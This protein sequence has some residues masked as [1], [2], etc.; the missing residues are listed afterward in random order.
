VQQTTTSPSDL[1]A[2]PLLLTVEEAASV[3]RIGRSA[4]YEACRTGTLKTVRV[5]RTIRVSRQGIEAMIAGLA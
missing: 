5:G 4:A 2:L 3:L 1:G